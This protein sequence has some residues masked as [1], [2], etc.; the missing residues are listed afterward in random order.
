MATKRG[1]A[2]LLKGILAMRSNNISM[3]NE[4]L[5]IVVKEVVSTAVGTAVSETLMMIGIDV[6]DPIRTQEQMASLRDI[7]KM[8]NDEEFKKDLAYIRR[9]RKSV[10]EVSSVGIKTAVGILITGFFGMIVFA[11][12]AYMEKL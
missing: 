7:A 3:T 1:P 5:Q 12:N 9:W 4:E 8:L 2:A 10:E 11:V 6:R